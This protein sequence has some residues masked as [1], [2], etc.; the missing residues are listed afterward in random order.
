MKSNLLKIESQTTPNNSTQFQFSKT[1][2]QYFGYEQKTKG[3]GGGS[4][5]QRCHDHEGQGGP[6]GEQRLTRD[7]HDAGQHHI[8]HVHADV[9]RIVQHRNG[10][11]PVN[12]FNQFNVLFIISFYHFF[13]SFPRPCKHLPATALPSGRT[14]CP[15]TWTIVPI[16]ISP[17]KQRSAINCEIH[18]SHRAGV[19]IQYLHCR[20]GLV[21][22]VLV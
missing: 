13:T 2:C 3:R 12:Q 7:H 11:F 15:A 16:C 10:H 6:V 9:G 21:K 8:V 17:P 14:K 4:P 1:C 19:L 18:Y 22:S 20:Y 5:D